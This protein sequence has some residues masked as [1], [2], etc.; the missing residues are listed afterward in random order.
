MHTPWPT[1]GVSVVNADAFAFL[2]DTSHLFDVIIVDLPTPTPR[3]LARLYSLNFYR[4]CKKH[5]KR[6][7]TLVTQATSPFSAVRAFVCI[8]K[9]MAE[10]GFS[11]LPYHNHIPTLGEWGFVLGVDAELLEAT[12]LKKTVQGCPSKRLRR[13]FSTGRP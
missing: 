8:H 9:T 3:E 13:A 11:V 1:P 2:Q 5:L 6:G 4:L 7:G 12:A 10:A